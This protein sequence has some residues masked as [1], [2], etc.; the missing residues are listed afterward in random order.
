MPFVIW[1]FFKLVS[2][3]I[4]PITR[5]KLKFN[6]NPC[7]DIPPEQ[8]M[9]SMGGEVEFEYDHSQY[10]PALNALAERRRQES[11][12][13]WVKGGKRIG[14]HDNY[15]RGGSGKSLAATESESESGELEEKLQALAVDTT[16]TTNVQ[17]PVNITPAVA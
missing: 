7:D 11:F 16:Q 14:E 1:G 6:A 8:L 12:E 3:F 13:R 10:W 9:K 2:S 5:E 15:L 17:T 4:D